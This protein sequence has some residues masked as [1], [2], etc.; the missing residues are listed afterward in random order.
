MKLKIKSLLLRKYCVI[1]ASIAYELLRPANYKQ[2]YWRKDFYWKKK[3][4]QDKIKPLAFNLIIIS[5]LMD[6]L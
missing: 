2:S 1:I 5:L 4:F 3:N 6:C